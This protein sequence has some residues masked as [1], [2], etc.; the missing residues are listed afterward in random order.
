MR[1]PSIMRYRTLPPGAAALLRAALVI[2]S[3][4]TS[5]LAVALGTDTDDV[6]AR[7]AAVAAEGWMEPDPDAGMRWRDAARMWLVHDAPDHIDRSILHAD[8]TTI[9]ARYL[10]H[11]LTALTHPNRDH[12]ADWIARHRRELLAACNAG[13]RTGLRELTIA[14]AKAAWTFADS[15]TDRTWHQSLAAATE[16]AARDEREL[17]DLLYL[18][19]HHTE[20]AGDLETAEHQYGR[21]AWLALTGKDH[22][23]AVTALTALVRVL[24]ARDQPARA[25][26]ALLELADLHHTAGDTAAHAVTLTEL[27][28]IML[29]GA[30]PE[31]ADIYLTRAIAQLNKNPDNPPALLAH[32]HELRGHAL[33]AVGKTTLARRAFRTAMTYTDSAD[34]PTRERLETLI[35]RTT[36]RRTQ[37]ASPST[38]R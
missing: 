15:P 17:F 36:P 32:V 34:T 29:T 10:D 18:S 4:A 14:T 26:D 28:E 16:P 22:H 23:R 38:D 7:L 13:I 25:A 35:R 11:H 24:R 31:L 33:W 1:F 12:A 8:D 5:D 21:A 27:G 3:T 6:T 9:A 30:R 19:A 2:D 37:P 20:R